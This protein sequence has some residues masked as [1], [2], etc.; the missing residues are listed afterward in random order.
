M[1]Q[2]SEVFVAELED[3]AGFSGVVARLGA[4][5]QWW[6]SLQ[7]LALKVNAIGD[8]ASS[9]EENFPARVGVATVDEFESVFAIEAGRDGKSSD[10]EGSVDHSNCC[11]RRKYGKGCLLVR[12][13]PCRF[14][15]PGWLAPWVENGD[16]Q[17]NGLA[18]PR[19]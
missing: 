8:A 19:V 5:V 7:G 1:A 9:E 15:T 2:P 14:P 11:K 13:V 17:M 3:L 10:G 16:A 6:S 12:F 18:L 4:R